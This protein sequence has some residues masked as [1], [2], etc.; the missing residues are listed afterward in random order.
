MSSLSNF[1]TTTTWQELTGVSD[2]SKY[3]TLQNTGRQD[4]RLFLGATPNDSDSNII[5]ASGVQGKSSSCVIDNSVNTEKVWV[6]GDKPTT[7]SI[8]ED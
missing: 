7:I 2:V 8:N 3:F 4:F 6:R 5:T 1:K